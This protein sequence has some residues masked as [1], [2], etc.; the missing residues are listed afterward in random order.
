MVGLR[1]V[2]VLPGPLYTRTR[3][4]DEFKAVLA[5]ELAHV[6]YHHF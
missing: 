3:G 5:H 2:I 6:K 1:P 4:D